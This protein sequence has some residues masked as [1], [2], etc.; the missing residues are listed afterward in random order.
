MYNKIVGNVDDL[1]SLFHNYPS[2]SFNNK[3]VPHGLGSS[4]VYATKS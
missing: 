3:D 4:F 2:D 1:L